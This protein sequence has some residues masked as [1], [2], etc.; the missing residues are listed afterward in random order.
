M[1]K[2]ALLKTSFAEAYLARRLYQASYDVRVSCHSTDM[3]TRAGADHR[4]TVGARAA[5]GHRRAARHGAGRGAPLREL[6]PG[7][8][9]GR[10]LAAG[11]GPHAARAAGRDIR[12][13]W[14]DC[15]WDG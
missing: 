9:P 4:H 2:E 7:P 10:V 12:A 8:Q 5:H 14:G 13:R 6:P 3:A 11:R 15:V 1:V